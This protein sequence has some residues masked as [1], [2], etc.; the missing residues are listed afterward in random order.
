MNKIQVF[1]NSTVYFSSALNLTDFINLSGKKIVVYYAKSVE[2]YANQIINSL[3]EKNLTCLPYIALE[4]EQNKSLECA[5]S[6]TQFL[7][8]NNLSR[9]DIL[10]NIGGGSVCDLGAFV[11]SLY[12]R[13]IKYINIPTTLLCASDA[14]IGG[15]TAV[16]FN[17]IKN[18]WGTFYQPY[19]TFIDLDF[20]KT[21][22]LNLIEEGLSEIVKYAIISK[23]FYNEFIKFNSIN[24]II[25]NLHAVLFNCLNIKADLVRK[26]QFDFNE[27]RALN[28]GHTVAHAVESKLNYQLSHGKAVAFGLVIESKIA[29]QVGLI[30]KNHLDQI[31]NLT[32]KFLQC[33]LKIDLL[34]LVDFMKK[35]K[36]NMG[37]E[38]AFSLPCESG[39]TLKTFT[40]EQLNQILIKIL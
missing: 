26:D 19:A 10:I 18:L 24:Q 39:V 22:P 40:A 3:N 8:D 16:D 36:K 32:A 37:E 17:G 27:R 6:L 2:S 29:H 23:H 15:K 33:D 11:A 1:N 12:K 21:L 35:D 31:L 38:I 5:I 7:T 13:G 30:T 9:S 20:L 14:S 28:L 25:N 34:S 4:G